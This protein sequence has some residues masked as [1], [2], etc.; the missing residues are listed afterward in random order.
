[1]PAAGRLVLAGSPPVGQGRFRAGTACFVR[2]VRPR[3]AGR[4]AAD[5][6]KRT[7]ER[8]SHQ[9]PPLAQNIRVC[10]SHVPDA[11]DVCQVQAEREEMTMTA[12]SEALVSARTATHTTI[13]SSLGDLTVVARDGAVTGLYF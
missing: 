10:S 5:R 13:Q 9:H 3:D 4:P 6:A 8:M 1:M 12:M 7:P 2:D 11:G